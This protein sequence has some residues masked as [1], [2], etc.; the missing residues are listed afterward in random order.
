[1]TEKTIPDQ[2]SQSG[3]D[4]SHEDEISLIDLA[5]VLAKHKK[6]IL[7]APLITA[8]IVALISLVIPNSYTATTQILPP[9]QQSGAASALLG[10]LGALSSLAGVSAGIKNPNDTYVAMLKSRTVSDNLIRRFKLQTVYDKKYS[11]D[12]RKKLEKAS[13]IIAGKDGVIVVTVDDRDPKRAA[14]L[15]NGYVEELQ[16]LTKVLAVTEA[17]Q[18]RLFFETQLLQ[19]KQALGDAEIALKQLQEKTGLIQLDAQAEALVKAG[20]ELKAQI[21]LKEV[22]LGA[23][24]T[25]ATGNNP[26][27]IR[28]EQLLGGLRSQLAKVEAGSVTTR[29]IPEAG[30]EYVR[31]VRD[32]KYAETV[33][34]LLAKQFEIAKIDE[35]KEGSMIQVLDRAVVPDKK[36]K[37]KRSLMVALATLAVGFGAVLWAFIVEGLNRAKEDTE[38][39]ARLAKFRQLLQWK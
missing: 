6:L 23:M 21:A 28:I 4:D 18:R 20:S 39:A 27:Y 3:W 37:P 17:S 2:K 11:S 26:D 38:N 31:K 13:A 7:G 36:S 25:F 1:M 10:Q 30:L 15:A 14:A 9:Q 8:V 35:A 24:R 12:T 22:E 34:E 16:K 33:Y 19:A 5:I 32:L 29:K